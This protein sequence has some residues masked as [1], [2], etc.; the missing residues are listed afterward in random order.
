MT[1]SNA[2]SMQHSTSPSPEPK[3]NQPTITLPFI[4]HTGPGVQDIRPYLIASKT[5]ME[6]GVIMCQNQSIFQ[7]F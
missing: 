5:D 7:D 1:I 3:H 2:H 6:C 4:V